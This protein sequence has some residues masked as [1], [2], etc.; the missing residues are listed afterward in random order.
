MMKTRDMNEEIT[1][2]FTPERDRQMLK[3]DAYMWNEGF[4][5]QE[6]AIHKA[7]RGTIRGIIFTLM[8]LGIL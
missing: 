5:A 2:R 1:I 7:G 6:S 8:R 3:A 4:Y